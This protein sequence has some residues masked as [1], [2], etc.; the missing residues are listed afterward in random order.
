M[1]SYKPLRCD[2]LQPWPNFDSSHLKHVIEYQMLKEI[3]HTLVQN[4]YFKPKESLRDAK[5]ALLRKDEMQK[6]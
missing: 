2:I 6:I 5:T 1:L 3:Q 4:V